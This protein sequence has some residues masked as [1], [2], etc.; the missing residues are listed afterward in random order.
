MTG[1]PTSHGELPASVSVSLRK[2]VCRCSEPAHS[3]AD[4]MSAGL[5]I[6]KA[7]FHFR[8]IRV[9]EVKAVCL[10]SEVTADGRPGAGRQMTKSFCGDDSCLK[11]G[12]W[13]P[14]SSVSHCWDLPLGM[15]VASQN[16]FMAATGKF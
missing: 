10:C 2:E 11:S 1:L 16:E 13:L 9:F 7:S 5:R 4:F 3:P 14:V 12:E 8:S 6:L 15:C